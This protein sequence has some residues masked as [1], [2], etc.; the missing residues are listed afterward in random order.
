MMRELRVREA[1]LLAC[2]QGR[3]RE[4]IANCAVLARSGRAQSICT[5]PLHPLTPL[6]MGSC[7]VALRP[8]PTWPSLMR[9]RA[10]V[11]LRGALLR[12][13]RQPRHP[14]APHVCSGRQHS[15]SSPTQT[16]G[17]ACIDAELGIVI[18]APAATKK[19]E[20]CAVTFK[21]ETGNQDR[22]STLRCTVWQPLCT[23]AST[24]DHSGGVGPAWFDQR[25][26]FYFRSPE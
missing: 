12:K 15:G 16:L 3:P 5:T 20:G 21:I 26:S 19:V 4:E 2:G 10:A 9:V 25:P 11:L 6:V 24:P 13:N 14:C 17:H 7:S 1:V 23:L 22:Q 18:F 8:P